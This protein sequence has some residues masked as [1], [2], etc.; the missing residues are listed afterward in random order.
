MLLNT[1]MAGV[2]RCRVNSTRCLFSKTSVDF[3]AYL[4]SKSGDRSSKTYAD[5]LNLPKMPFALSEYKADGRCNERENYTRKVIYP[6]IDGLLIFIFS[7][8]LRVC[9]L[10]RWQILMVSTTGSKRTM[11]E[12]V[13]LFTMDHRMPMG[14]LTLVTR[15]TR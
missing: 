8:N 12:S 11:W 15:S 7:S 1:S 2:T 4:S 13:S 6:K 9:D 5:T 10:N 14:I 3:P